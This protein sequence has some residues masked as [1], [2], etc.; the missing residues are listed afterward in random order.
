[1]KRIKILMVDDD[2]EMCHEMSEILRDEGFFV[3]LA[4]DGLQARRL[5]DEYEYD[6]VLLD[7]KIPK[8]SGFEVLSGLKAKK[9][10]TKA[11]I[12][13]GRPIGGQVNTGCIDKEKTMAEDK[14]LEQADSIINKPFNIQELIDNIKK[15]V[16]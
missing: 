12:L 9:T 10:G 15:I 5:I 3:S 2:R 13:T 8:L 4:F 6:I 1:M 16:K 7:L 11:I 14:L